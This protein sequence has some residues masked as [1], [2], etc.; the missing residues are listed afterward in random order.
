MAGCSHDCESC[1]SKCGKES[2]LVKQNELSN[3][4]KVIGVVSGKGGVGKS[5]V[6]SLLAVGM[7]REGRKV[8]VVGAGVP[9]TSP[10]PPL[11]GGRGG[12]GGLPPMPGRD[13]AVGV[14]AP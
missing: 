3:V 12:R 13:A 8:A 5:L 10:H 7:A 11:R 1:S 6:T 14:A 9:R 4:K 2:F